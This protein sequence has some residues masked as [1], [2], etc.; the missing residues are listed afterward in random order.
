MSLHGKLPTPLSGC[1][2]LLALKPNQIHILLGRAAPLV[3]QYARKRLQMI[4]LVLTR[5]YKMEDPK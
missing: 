3:T 4:R 1:N 2:F 5:T